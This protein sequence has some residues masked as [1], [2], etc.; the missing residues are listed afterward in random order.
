MKKN[1]ILFIPLFMISFLFIQLKLGYCNDSDYAWGAIAKNGL[2]L[3]IAMPRETFS[4]KEPF[5]VK[6]AMRNTS[7]K[8][9]PTPFKEKWE[10]M[11]V[12]FVIT[13]NKTIVAQG[14]NVGNFFDYK[15]DKF[16][17]LKPG[18]TITGYLNI[19]DGLKGLHDFAES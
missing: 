15:D 6:L 2:Q 17:I 19:T 10:W 1:S 11:A 3:G 9:V 14:V 13:Q 4:K 8:E 18:D 5:V 7:T 16:I 12:E